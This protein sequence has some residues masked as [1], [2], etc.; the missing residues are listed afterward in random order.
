MITTYIAFAAAIT[1]LIASPGPVVALV[2]SDSRRRW[3]GRTILGGVLS[4]Q[5]LLVT[6]L[7][8]IYLALD[9][10]PAVLHAGQVLGGVY[11]AWLGYNALLDEDDGEMRIGERPNAYFWRALKVGLSNPKDILFFLAFLPSFI[12]PVEPFFQQAL[13]LL[14]IWGAIDLS[15]LVCYSLLSRRVMA[16]RF[17]R[18]ALGHAPGYILIALGLLSCVSGLQRLFN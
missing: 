18:L 1:L 9:I 10:D 13:T 14:L 12:L 2:M 6:A 4:A 15:I 7:V 16:S 5:I 8:L 17:G 3:P 11:L